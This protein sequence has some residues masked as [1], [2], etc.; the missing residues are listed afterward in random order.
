MSKR[1]IISRV[2]IFFLIICGIL[3][4]SLF[5]T[6]NDARA[7]DNYQ[8]QFTPQIT[9]LSTPIENNLALSGFEVKYEPEKWN[10]P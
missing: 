2:T 5:V 3:A 8:I 6:T 1:K 4:L 7:C 10:C 9:A